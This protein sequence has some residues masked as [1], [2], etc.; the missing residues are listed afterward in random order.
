MFEF[1]SPFVHL[2]GTINNII[3]SLFVVF[4]LRVTAILIR[5]RNR[6]GKWPQRL[7]SFKR[8]C[9]NLVYTGLFIKTDINVT[10]LLW[11]R[12]RILFTT[13]RRYSLRDITSENHVKPQRNIT[14]KM[15]DDGQADRPKTMRRNGIETVSLLTVF[16]RSKQ[17]SNLIAIAF[18]KTKTSRSERNKFANN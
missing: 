14:R 7:P 10:A 4:P 15:F 13:A 2:G 5:P 9:R 3:D 6:S 1:I 11:R 17:V 18:E 12:E 16:C 8:F